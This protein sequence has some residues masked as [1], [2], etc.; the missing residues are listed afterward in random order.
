[1][2]APVIDAFAPTWVLVSAGF[3]AHRA[4]PLAEL[5]LSAGDFGLLAGDVAD[6]APAD[7]RVI[8]FLEGGYDLEALRNS[9]AATL[10]VFGG[11]DSSLGTESEGIT[12]GDRGL[13]AVAAAA[14]IRQRAL[15]N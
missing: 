14:A 3:D 13:E 2:A 11:V 7:G 10:G 5:L 12:G 15:L 4:D 8:A 6:F 1:V 9:V